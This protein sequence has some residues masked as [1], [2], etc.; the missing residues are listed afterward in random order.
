MIMANNLLRQF[1]LHADEYEEKAIEVLRSGWYVL[2]K[3]VKSFEQEWADYIGAKY[4]VG[5]ASGLDALWIS[6]RLLEIKAGDEVIVSANAYI[7]CVMGITINGATPV[8]VEPDMYDNID[9]DKIEAAVTSKTKAILV[10]HLYGESCDM[11]KIMDI[12]RRYNLKIV[13]DC[14]QSHGNHWHGKTV[15]TFGDIGCFSFYPT[16]GCGAFGDAGCIVT[17]NATL[18]KKFRIFRNYGSEKHY[19]NKVVGSNSRLDEIQAGLLRVK[20]SHLD[21]FN[22]ERCRIADRYLKEITNPMVQLPQIRPEADSTWH[23]FVIHTEKRDELQAYLEANDISTLIHYPIP[24]HLSEA[25]QYLGKKSGD[26]PIAE[27]Y[28]DE[29][30][31]L[32]MYNGMTDEEQSKVIITINAFKR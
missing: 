20:L 4:C 8:F 15:G 3:E 22:E 23:Q 5:L 25:Y 18:A 21:E 2:G 13:E 12:S 32:P 10:V 7:A 27:K 19:Q 14:A 1:S 9:A 31:S 6:F 30:L 26:Y 11:T 17:N 24:P 28:A 16:K 29:V